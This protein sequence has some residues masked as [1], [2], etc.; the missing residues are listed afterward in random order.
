V[1]SQFGP[2]TPSQE[3]GLMHSPSMFLEDIS[4][5]ALTFF[6]RGM[7]FQLVGVHLWRHG[8][9][10]MWVSKIL[11]LHFWILCTK[12]RDDGVSKLKII[13]NRLAS[14]MMSNYIKV[15]CVLKNSLFFQTPYL[16]VLFRCF[17]PLTIYACCY[18]TAFLG[19]QSFYIASAQIHVYF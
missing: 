5:P 15:Y 3:N 2:T 1:T 18:C 9:M 6:R 11:W 7:I 8:L 10:G 4:Q 16:A 14:F 13:K 12:Q 19:C 17:F